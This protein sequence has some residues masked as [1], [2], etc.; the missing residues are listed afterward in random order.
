MIEPVDLLEEMLGVDS[1]NTS[2]GGP[3]EQAMAEAWIVS[4][5]YD[6]HAGQFFLPRRQWN[7]AHMCAGLVAVLAFLLFGEVP[8]KWVW[9]GAAVIFSS[10]LYIAHREAA[11]SRRA[12]RDES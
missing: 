9:L 10:T 4:S 8:D 6:K 12:K 2:M 11:A 1:A 7:I 3:G 5:I